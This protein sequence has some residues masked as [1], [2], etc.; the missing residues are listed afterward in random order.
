MS[1]AQLHLEVQLP[2]TPCPLAQVMTPLL[3]LTSNQLQLT[4]HISECAVHVL[5]GTDLHVWEDQRRQAELTSVL[6][7]KEEKLQSLR[8]GSRVTV[9]EVDVPEDEQLDQQVK[10]TKAYKTTQKACWSIAQ[11]GCHSL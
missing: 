1:I 6:Q 9:G 8:E 2:P 3:P 11:F 10:L 7:Q 5:Q 4:Y